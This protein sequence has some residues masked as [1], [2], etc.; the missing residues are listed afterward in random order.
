LLE[1][2]KLLLASFSEPLLLLGVPGLEAAAPGD[3]APDGLAG[4]GC[5]D[6]DDRWWWRDFDLERFV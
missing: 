4:A 6:D 5:P 3:A 2:F 1:S